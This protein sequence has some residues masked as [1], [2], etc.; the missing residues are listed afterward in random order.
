MDTHLSKV[1]GTIYGDDL[2]LGPDTPRSKVFG[3]A[4]YL[5]DQVTLVVQRFPQPAHVGLS[6]TLSDD[7]QSAS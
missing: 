6:K 1:F 7:P 2:G 4:P 3:A 5:H